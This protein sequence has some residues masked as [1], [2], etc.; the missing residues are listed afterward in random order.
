M[1]I[2]RQHWFCKNC[3]I[4]VE[5]RIE[6]G[7]EKAFRCAECASLMQEIFSQSG[8]LY[9]KLIMDFTRVR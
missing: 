6:T 3:E 7:F 5:T 2:Y 9:R 4:Q 1:K 8:V